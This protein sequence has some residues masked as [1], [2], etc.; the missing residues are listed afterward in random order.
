MSAKVEPNHDEQV[1][2]PSK[3]TVQDTAPTTEP[4]HPD[5]FDRGSINPG[6]VLRVQQTMGNQAVGRLL[7]PAPQTNP[8][9]N[10]PV[11][12]RQ[13][14]EKTNPA[15]PPPATPFVEPSR[16]WESL[17]NKF[18]KL[19][20]V[21]VTLNDSPLVRGERTDLIRELETMW[22]EIG[23]PG[24]KS[25]SELARLRNRLTA[26]EKARAEDRT[27]ALEN[28][29]II[30]EEYQTERDRLAGSQEL[31]DQKALEYL[32]TD[33]QLARKRKEAAGRYLRFDDIAFFGAA[34]AN[35]TYSQK[36]WEAALGEAIATAPTDED[37]KPL[38][39]W[40]WSEFKATQLAL[41]SGATT[42]HAMSALRQ[43]LRFKLDSAIR[44]QIRQSLLTMLELGETHRAAEGWAR[45]AYARAGQAAD[46]LVDKVPLSGHGAHKWAHRLHIAGKITIFVDIG[47]SAI[48]IWASPPKER[49]K[50]I[51][52]QTSRIAG[53]I[54]GVK[55][56]ARIGARIGS[57]FG[58][59]GAA[60]GGFLGGLAGGFVGAFT[61]KK[62]AASLAETLW[63]P[64]DTYI[65]TV[66]R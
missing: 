51:F 8:Q 42:M 13:P 5:R 36:G 35:E 48:D 57:R 62:I 11:I 32:E 22:A 27:L 4:P 54:A 1:A 2:S 24:E 20:I 49:P 12:Q 60:V 30:E 18:E 66:T 9:N 3:S 55:A 23:A 14:T 53:G 31:S 47:V 46:K 19:M 33:Y 43:T 41:E 37:D 38:R 26:F 56:G 45:A 40:P 63:P 21:V 7:T 52:I 39:T 28:W 34:M 59:K 10:S 58:P 64:E 6:R 61:A 44:Y 65:D 25:D 17:Q 15:A 50:K 29:K 16:S